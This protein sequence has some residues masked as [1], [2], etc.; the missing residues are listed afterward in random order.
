MMNIGFLNANGVPSGNK[1]L[2]KYKEY[3]NLLK[4]NKLN[5]LLETGCTTKAP[6]LIDYRQKIC[7][8]NPVEEQKNQ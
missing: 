6:K 4:D 3:N 8:N 5:V 1:N 2:K 7:Q